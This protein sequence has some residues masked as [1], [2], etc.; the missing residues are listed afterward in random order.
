MPRRGRQH[1]V[2]LPCRTRR[3]AVRPLTTVFL[4]HSSGDGVDRCE[5]FAIFADLSLPGTEPILAT[6]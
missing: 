4:N 1:F 2:A 3:V 6:A 5:L